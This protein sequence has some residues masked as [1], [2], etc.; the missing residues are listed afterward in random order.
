[1]WVWLVGWGFC[2]NIAYVWCTFDFVSSVFQVNIVFHSTTI[3][4]LGVHIAAGYGRVFIFVRVWTLCTGVSWVSAYIGIHTLS[5]QHTF[6]CI[7]LFSP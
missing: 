1:M 6:V 7:S 2:V 5:A 4:G 3:P